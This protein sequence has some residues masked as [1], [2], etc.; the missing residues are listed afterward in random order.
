MLGS[1]SSNG[2]NHEGLFL[3]RSRVASDGRNG[4]G[5][6]LLAVCAAVVQVMTLLLAV[7]SGC[8][9]A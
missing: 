5:L 3:V 8:S 6:V 2:C 4:V 1:L 7:G 9:L